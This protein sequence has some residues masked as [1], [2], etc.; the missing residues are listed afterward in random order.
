MPGNDD[1]DYRMPL[2]LSHRAAIACPDLEHEVV[3]LM[4]CHGS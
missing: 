1:A 4:E 2:T 3:F